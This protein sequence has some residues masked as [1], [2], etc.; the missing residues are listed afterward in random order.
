[1][2][3]LSH[4][5]KKSPANMQKTKKVSLRSIYSIVAIGVMTVFS[6]SRSRQITQEAFQQ[7]STKE[8]PRKNSS[9]HLQIHT[10][11]KEDRSN[12]SKKGTTIDGI[13]PNNNKGDIVDRSIY[14]QLRFP[15]GDRL[16]S[17][18]VRPLSLMGYAHCYRHIFCIAE[19]RG[20]LTKYFPALVN[21]TCPKDLHQRLPWID[22]GEK[23]LFDNPP[24]KEPGIYAFKRNDKRLETWTKTHMDCAFDDVM[25][26]K[27]GQ[28]I[29]DAS[30]G[31]NPN[32]INKTLAS[33]DLFEANKDPNTVTVAINIRRGDFTDW[34]RKVY[35]DQYYVILLR[36]LR[37]LLVKAGRIPEVHLFSEDY[38]MIDIGRNITRN[39]T[40]YEGLVEHYHFAPDMRT[41]R[42]PH[43]MNMD[44]NLRD[45]R[46]F[47]QA[48]I[49]IVGGSFSRIPALGRPLQP[50]AE[51]GLPLTIDCV[52]EKNLPPN[53]AT[54][55]FGWSK[56]GSKYMPDKYALKNL[57]QVFTQHD[58]VPVSF[59]MKDLMDDWNATYLQN[60]T[61]HDGDGDASTANTS[62]GDS[63]AAE[64]KKESVTKNFTNY[65]FTPTG[66]NNATVISDTPATTWLDF[67]AEI[68]RNFSY[69]TARF[70]RQEGHF[71]DTMN[72]FRNK[73]L[74]QGFPAE[75]FHTYADRKFPAFI[76]NDQ[77]YQEHL[78]FL[79]DPKH[80]S[81]RGGGY[82]FWKPV[83]IQHH[84]NATRWGDFVVYCDSDDHTGEG[85]NLDL[86][87][88]LARK[89]IAK[90]H[91]SSREFNLAIK[92]YRDGE[93]FCCPEKHWS[94]GVAYQHFCPGR[95]QTS[96]DSGQ[97]YANFLVV[98]K[99]V[100]TVELIDGWA[101][102]AANYYLINDVDNRHADWPTVKDHRHDQSLL[103]GSLKCR[104]S[105]DTHREYVQ[106][107]Y[108]TSDL[109]LLALSPCKNVTTKVP[110]NGEGN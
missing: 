67:E 105:A 39:W 58:T 20:G 53:T 59:F 1:M 101:N 91:N 40:M 60:D 75:R 57:P 13:E 12:T 107:G 56:Y 30:L 32:I 97:Y 79:D 96:D 24:L 28:V 64:S 106:R 9:V 17:N 93:G 48:D 65:T 26:K 18:I 55:F 89:M 74:G 33:E 88:L 104:Y 103:S 71:A 25:R 2:K 16:G 31:D 44:L 110:H 61:I 15:R 72:K 5:T 66:S 8:L 73:V 37:F 21:L 69:V 95:N 36:H 19:G 98:K 82:W 86:L 78:A 49:L 34:Q 87:K 14:V 77:R 108:K 76:Q 109:F 84:L 51:T 83:L 50:N 4:L 22:D 94:K 41:A 47:V 62:G 11:T 42:N 100:A 23:K 102:A 29:V 10:F 7:S 85:N 63:S 27:W 43:V 6:L 99:T 80:P 54:Y 35:L 90:E 45:W 92:R 38:G 81:A 46:H 68:G 52:F 3:P 70:H